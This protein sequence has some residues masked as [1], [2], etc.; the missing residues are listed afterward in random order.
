MAVLSVGVVILSFFSTFSS[1]SHLFQW[2]GMFKQFRSRFR[3]KLC[4]CFF[5]SGGHLVKWSATDLALSVQCHVENSGHS[6][7]FSILVA[8]LLVGAEHFFCNFGTGHKRYSSVKLFW[9]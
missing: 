2:S 6:I 3:E 7:C 5:S 4:F 8:V 1:G 9:F